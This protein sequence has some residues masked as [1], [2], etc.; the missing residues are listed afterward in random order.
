MTNIEVPRNATPG[1]VF[2]LIA[3]YYDTHP[4]LLMPDSIDMTTHRADGYYHALRERFGAAPSGSGGSRWADLHPAGK[5]SYP[6]IEITA[7][8]NKDRCSH[9]GCNL[10]HDSEG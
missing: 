5:S 8:A 2:R 7:F 4:D 10:D 6:R 3:D 9:P 1:E